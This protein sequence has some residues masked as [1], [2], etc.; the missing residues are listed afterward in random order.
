L[1]RFQSACRII[2]FSSYISYRAPGFSC[3]SIPN[4]AGLVR[5]LILDHDALGFPA[6]QKSSGKPANPPVRSWLP[7][8]PR[9]A[10]A[11][12]RFSV[13]TCITEMRLD[14]TGYQEERAFSRS[15]PQ[16][17]TS[18]TSRQLGNGYKIRCRVAGGFGSTSSVYFHLF[19][20]LLG[21]TFNGLQ[22][23]LLQVSWSFSP[24]KLRLT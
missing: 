21:T 19:T 3:G 6:L 5:Y 10:M 22:E 24:V 2:G 20:G 17:R 15:T 4:L 16:T 12:Q 23:I 11:L 7:Q 18:S 9:W 8:P 14:L 13:S 1:S